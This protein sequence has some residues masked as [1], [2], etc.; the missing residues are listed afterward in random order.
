MK[1]IIVIIIGIVL[2]LSCFAQTVGRLPYYK[3]RQHYV[4]DTIET[5]F[6]GDTLNFKTNQTFFN[7]NKPIMIN[8]DTVSGSSA[9]VSGSLFKAVGNTPVP[10]P[11][12][13]SGAGKIFN[14][15]STIFGIDAGGGDSTTIKV[16][17]KAY[18]GGTPYFYVTD[19]GFRV[20]GNEHS[21]I[22]Y[23][24]SGLSIHGRGIIDNQ[25]TVPG[26]GGASSIMQVDGENA[27]Y[28]ELLTRGLLE[29]PSTD[30]TW[31]QDSSGVEMSLNTTPVFSVNSSGLI[32]AGK[33]K[34]HLGS[35][36]II[37]NPATGI[38]YD[39]GGASVFSVN[40]KG[41]IKSRV[42]HAKVSAD[43][44]NFVSGSVQNRWYKIN[45]GLAVKD[46]VGI[47]LAGDSLKI[48]EAGDYEIF[49]T[50]GVATSNTND[51]I[52]CK[53]FAN[54]AQIVPALSR[55]IINSNGTGSQQTIPNIWYYHGAIAG[56]WLSFRILNQTGA[57]AMTVTDLSVYIKKVPE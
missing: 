50:I 37:L 36:S 10:Y 53:L 16:G 40:S 38:H 14:S 28:Y 5:Y 52:R 15:G 51:K 11:I 6:A 26:H 54:N 57:R 30:L 49:V 8:G 1:K 35:D 47:T 22:G 2:T 43:S 39:K 20:S 42:I 19:S 46:T 41:E 18:K 25:V 4:G 45:A 9:L 33:L 31:R 13:E 7:F 48:Q 12:V 3:I 23:D 17:I 44:I 27:P 21:S 34:A 55:F 29:S 24:T 32:T 56:Q